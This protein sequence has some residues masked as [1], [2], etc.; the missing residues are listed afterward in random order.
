MAVV[1]PFANDPE[2][3]APWEQGYLDGYSEPEATHFPPL[4]GEL[5]EIYFLGEAVGRNDRENEAVGEPSVPAEMGSEFIRFESAPDGTLIAVPNEYPPGAPM[6]E[7]AQ[8]TV[9]T[10]GQGFYVAIYNGPPG[11][12]GDPAGLLLDLGSE[13]A[14]SKL[15]RMLAEAAASGA[16]GIIKFGGLAIGVLMSILTPSPI[17]KETHFRSFLPDGRP[18]AYVVLTPQI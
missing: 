14:Q 18:I 4:K 9:S 2:R 11:A 7:D 8:I 13:V 17:L 5:L 10:L 6:R 16:R 1:N 12:V 3:A 15:E